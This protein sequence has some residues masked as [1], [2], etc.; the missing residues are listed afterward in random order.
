MPI[1][2]LTKKIITFFLSRKVAIT[3]LILM[4]LLLV[5]SSQLPNINMM[6]KEEQSYYQEKLPFAYNISKTMGGK[7]IISSPWFYVLPAFIFI[8][9]LLCTIERLIRTKKKDIGFWGSMVFHAGLL[10]IIVAAMITKVTLFEGEVLLTEGFDFPLGR[11][12]YIRI[13]REPES[14]ITLPEGTI[15]MTKYKNIYQGDF[16]IEHIANVS[17]KRGDTT[18]ERVIKV[19]H[20]LEIDDLQYTLNKYGFTPA[21]VV[22][23]QEGN[24]LVDAFINL[25]VITGKEDSF[26]IPGKNTMFYVRFH[27]DFEMTEDGPT[28]RSRI[29]N[30]PVVAVKVKSWGKETKFHHIKLGESAN[31]M[32]Y[33]IA[34]PELKYWAHFLVKRDHGIPVFI[35]AFF[36]VVGG[37]CIR[38]L[39]ME[40][41]VVRENQT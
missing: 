18:L 26:Q 3:L 22:K 1:K 38:F 14:G 41:K 40:R 29:P 31:I 7:G 25:V 30:N 13:D 37:L 9:T 33:N 6:G 19:N 28:S 17:I 4:T 20:P 36:L 39:T 35:V 24:V 8:S 27:P 5:L 12:G 15:T 32:G 34:F 23:D 2:P 16:A 11:E 21:F 10:S